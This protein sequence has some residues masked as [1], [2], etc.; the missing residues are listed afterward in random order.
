MIDDNQQESFNI[1]N[2]LQKGSIGQLASHFGATRPTIYKSLRYQSNSYLA[3]EIR[4]FAVSMIA[5]RIEELQKALLVLREQMG[6]EHQFNHS[7]NHLN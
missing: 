5:V 6:K 4:S 3:R 2:Y 1:E 7:N